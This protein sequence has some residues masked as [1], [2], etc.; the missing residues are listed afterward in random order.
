MSQ[1]GDLLIGLVVLIVAA[2]VAYR[3]GAQLVRRTSTVVANLAVTMGLVTTL[4][5]AVLYYGRLELARV[6]P[7]SNVILMGNWI[8]L[9]AALLMGSIMAQ[10]SIPRWRRLTVAAILGALAWS[11]V[12][13]D[14]TGWRE[15]RS[16]AVFWEGL[17][18]QTS[19]ASCSACSA[20]TL[21]RHYGIQAT[22][23]EMTALCLTRSDGTPELGLYR[24]LKIKTR[25]TA[26]DVQVVRVEPQDLACSDFSPVLALIQPSQPPEVRRPFMHQFRGPS[27]AVI[28]CGYSDAGLFVMVDPVAGLKKCRSEEFA[29]DW[30]A[31]GL[32]LVRR[33]S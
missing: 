12:V 30:P 27:H 20:A 26:W 24:G 16:T 17:L 3:L 10:P 1:N 32:K 19:E 29:S 14:L 28:L 13:R 18:Q 25:G 23:E 7:V 21:L 22:E 5:F 31:K 9:G 8:P 33:Q 4:F 11:T 15:S 6:L 2:T